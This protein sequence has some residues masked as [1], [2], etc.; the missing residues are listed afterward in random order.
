MRTGGDAGDAYLANLF[1]SRN[2]ALS[3]GKRRGDHAEMTVNA[4]EAVVLNQHFQ[5][6]RPLVLETDHRAGCG[7]HYRC[8]HWCRQIDSI[9]VGAGLRLVR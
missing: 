4:N 8:A 5:A 9:V 6:T 1:A 2:G 3:L 7:S